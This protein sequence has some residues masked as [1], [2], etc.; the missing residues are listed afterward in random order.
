MNHHMIHAVVEVSEKYSETAEAGLKAARAIAATEAFRKYDWLKNV[1]VRNVSGNFRG[2][3]VNKKWAGVFHF[4]EDALKPVEKLA[5]ITGLAANILKASRET[6]AILKSNDTWD[7]KASRLST[8]VTS[9]V[10]R[11]LAGAIPAGA[12]MLALSLSGYCQMASLAGLHGAMNLDQK[13]KLA[14][15][16][17]TS[18]FEKVTDGENMYVFIN[19]HLVVR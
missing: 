9:L 12:H 14:D 13:V 4:A 17:L 15:A 1:P 10:T 5:L 2:M 7:S 19:K 8:Q 3:V 6:E 18:G 11:T 16:S